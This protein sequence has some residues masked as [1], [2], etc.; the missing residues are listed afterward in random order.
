[1]NKSKW[2]YNNETPTCSIHNEAG[3]WHKNSNRP[4]NYGQ[5]SCKSCNKE[6]AKKTRK[7]NKGDLSWELKRCVDYCRNRRKDTTIT[8]NDLKE[9]WNKQKGL[10]AITELEMEH[11]SGIGV[12]NR[13]KFSVDRIDNSKGYHKD[14]VW[15]VCEFVNR[16]KGDMTNEELHTL[17]LGIIK[18][19]VQ[20]RAIVS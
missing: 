5:W 20:D 18:N 1:M 4:P 8:Y 9:L 10:C 6:R 12:I 19:I 7:D 11:T 13:M 16:A 15:L 3:V 2:I 14:N 17:A